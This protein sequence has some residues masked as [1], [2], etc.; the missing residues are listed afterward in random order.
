MPPHLFYKF[1]SSEN[2]ELL[3]TSFLFFVYF[4]EK[5]K[6]LHIIHH[7]VSHKLKI[8]RALNLI[9]KDTSDVNN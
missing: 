9:Y 6:R 5:I 7:K 8:W 2:I 3:P 1:P 4:M